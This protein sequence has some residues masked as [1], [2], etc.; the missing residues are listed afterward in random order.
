[1]RKAVALMVVLTF[2]LAVAFAS[3]AAEAKKSDVVKG[4]V[5]KIEGNKLTIKQAD[6]KEATVEVKDA[7]G[8]KVGDK[9]TVKGGVVAKEKAKDEK[10]PKKKAVEGC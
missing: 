5:T 2:I 3:F 7:K 1:M 8:I 4:T 10:S 6:G 9:V